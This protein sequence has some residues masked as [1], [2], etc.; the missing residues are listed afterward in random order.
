M[1]DR[2]KN[3]ALLLLV[4]ALAIIVFIQPL[5][6]LLSTQPEGLDLV[7]EAWVV[8]LNDFV[9]SDKLDPSILSQGAIRGIIES[10]DDPYS[11]YL[12]VKQY[13]LMQT[14]LEGSFGGI[15]AEVTIADGQVTVVAPI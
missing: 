1:S 8:I 6:S 9:D 4:V 2:A 5:S 12:D 3:V 11:A 15:G 14:R 7:E 13:E 10:L